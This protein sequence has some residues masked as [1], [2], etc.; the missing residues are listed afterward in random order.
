MKRVVCLLSEL[1]CACTNEPIEQRI[2]R[3]R[4]ELVWT[5]QELAERL[6]ISRVAV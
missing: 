1:P 3:L 4:N 6:A 2:A 5:Q